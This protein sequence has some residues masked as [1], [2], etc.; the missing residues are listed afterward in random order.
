MRHQQ[1]ELKTGKADHA[2]PDGEDKTTRASAG[3]IRN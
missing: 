3:G 2:L 1:M